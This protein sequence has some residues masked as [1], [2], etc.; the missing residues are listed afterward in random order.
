MSKY[1]TYK[2]SLWDREDEFANSIYAQL[3]RLFTDF[4]RD[5]D[6]DK[7]KKK[8]RKQLSNFVENFFDE[9]Y[10][11]LNLNKDEE[12][13]ESKVPWPF[14]FYNR[15]KYSQTILSTDLYLWYL[16][17]FEE[18]YQTHSENIKPKRKAGLANTKM[19]IEYLK[20]HEMDPDNALLGLPPNPQIHDR[21]DDWLRKPND[22]S[23]RAEAL[24][25]SS[26][27]NNN[28]VVDPRAL[29]FF[30]YPAKRGDLVVAQVN[31]DVISSYDLRHKFK[32]S[33]SSSSSSYSSSSSQQQQGE[34]EGEG[35]EGGG[36]GVVV[37]IARIKDAVEFNRKLFL[38]LTISPK[39]DTEFSIQS[40]FCFPLETLMPHSHMGWQSQED[41]RDGGRSFQ[42]IL[43]LPSLW[44]SFHS[45][46]LSISI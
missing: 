2:E 38:K 10:S 11:L 34:G 32:S 23:Q 41:E 29:Y 21:F 12:N 14:I 42:S 19:I 22:H 26:I 3:D 30:K 4:E 27:H 1:N 25:L 44:H 20:S 46:S 7:K 28:G 18:Y 6:V 35:G 15:M 5:F 43:F 37:I 45:Q 36:G 40:T 31:D 9:I 13:S 8:N 24:S 39:E 33:S 16:E 17:I